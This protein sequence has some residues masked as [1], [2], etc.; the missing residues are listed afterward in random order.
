MSSPSPTGFKEITLGESGIRI[1]LR[2]LQTHKE[3]RACVSLQEETWGKG[4]PD[5]VPTSILMVN[6]KIGGITV[7]AF[8]DQESLIGFVFGL[9]GFKNGEPVHWSNMLAVREDSRGRSIGTQL[10]LY[11]R[12]AVLRLGI[13]RIYWTFDPLVA[14]NAHVNINH[15]GAEIDEYVPDMYSDEGSELHRELGMDR[16]IVVWKI[17]SPQVEAIVAGAPQPP[18]ELDEDLPVVNTERDQR[19]EWLPVVEPL[20]DQPKILVEVPYDIQS[21]RSL[22]SETA[23]QWRGATRHAFLQYLGQGYHVTSFIRKAEEKRC[24]YLLKK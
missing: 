22:S 13:S 16:F 8:D 15:L 18:I 11:Q 19:G 9:A 6:Q 7:G 10:K 12:D 3:Y 5:L 1:R 2:P 21:I 24:F 14:R 17:A 4:F 20:P 23:R